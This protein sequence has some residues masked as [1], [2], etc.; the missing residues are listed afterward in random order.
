MSVDK[1]RFEARYVFGIEIKCLELV[2]CDFKN[3]CRFLSFFLP[4]VILVAGFFVD[5][6]ISVV[7]VFFV[8]FAAKVVAE[9]SIVIA[10]A[11]LPV[12]EK[13]EIHFQINGTQNWS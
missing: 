7:V 6:R 2:I 10:V 5:L 4:F 8:F 11:T 1:A 13:H 12:K 3:E 9:L